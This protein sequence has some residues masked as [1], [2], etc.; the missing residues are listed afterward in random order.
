MELH[1]LQS[2]LFS[3]ERTQ[4]RVNP[5]NPDICHIVPLGKE[6][7]VSILS[8]E[9]TLK[10]LIMNIQGS[11]IGIVRIMGHIVMAMWKMSTKLFVIKSILRDLLLP[12]HDIFLHFTKFLN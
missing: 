12:N 11:L 5:S 6:P 10:L 2:F 7:A 9:S 1:E 8:A 3:S 4:K